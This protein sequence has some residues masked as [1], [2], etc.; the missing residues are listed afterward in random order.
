MLASILVAL[1]AS[2]ILILGVAH[3]VYTFSGSKLLP[4]D[5][6]LLSAMKHVSPGVSNETTMWN[7]WV[8][9]NASH[10]LGAILFGLV[11]G[12]LALAHPVFLFGS[13][14]LSVVGFLMLAGLVIL[15]RQYW[16]SIPFRG[17]SISMVCYTAGHVIARF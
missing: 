11:Y 16:F 6:E 7:A 4:R 14:F 13:A 17:I 1:S 8:G 9:F 3:L 10:S 15:S 5:A 12:Y 2:V